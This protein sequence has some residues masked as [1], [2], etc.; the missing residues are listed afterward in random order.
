[1][2]DYRFKLMLISLLLFTF[3]AGNN[4]FSQNSTSTKQLE[5]VS[6]VGSGITEMKPPQGN[7]PPLPGGHPDGGLP[8]LQ[9]G[10]PDGGLP[11]KGEMPNFPV[12]PPYNTSGIKTKFMDV[13]YGSISKTQTLDVYIP[14][15]GKAPYPVILLIHGG[16]FMV[17]SSKGG[18]ESEIINEGNKRGFA[19]VS[20]NYRKS[21]EAR[22]P[23][24]INDAKA[25]VRFVRANASKYGFNPNKIVAWGGSAG[26]NLVAMLGTTSNVDYLDGDNKE[27][28][29]YSS[30]V[31]AVVDWFG[32]C[33]F[34]LYDKQFE[35][36]GVVTPFG[37]VFSETSPESLYLGQNPAKDEAFTEKANPMTYIPT[38]NEKDAPSFLIQHGT[39]DLNIPYTQSVNFAKSLT[40]KLGSEKVTIELLKNARHGDPAFS[41]PENFNKVFGFI[42]N[43]LNK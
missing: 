31:Q 29:S 23:R 8:P 43:A 40:T 21:G 33:D 42:E 20:I 41:T 28:S 5:P 19:V 6:P 10:H 36:L 18:H 38:M 15:T 25:A 39:G 1:M 32:P 13:V 12:E 34:M 27:N 17:G 30:A 35:E 37:S 26:G 14:N 9:G 11:P 4:A 7:L 24:A 22:F 2:K 3:S 16:G